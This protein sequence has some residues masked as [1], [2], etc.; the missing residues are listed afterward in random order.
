MKR[1]SVCMLLSL[2]VVW[3]LV[4]SVTSFAEEGKWTKKT[5]ISIGRWAFGTSVVDGKIVTV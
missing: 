3:L 2:C 5:D 4:F 1:F